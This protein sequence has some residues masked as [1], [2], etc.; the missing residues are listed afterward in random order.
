[1]ILRILLFLILLQSEGT[2]VRWGRQLWAVHNFTKLYICFRKT[3][4]LHEVLFSSEFLF[5]IKCKI[6]TAAQQK[7]YDKL[8]YLCWKSDSEVKVFWRLQGLKFTQGWDIHRSHNTIVSGHVVRQVLRR[9][10]IKTFWFAGSVPN[11][12]VCRYWWNDSTLKPF[13][14]YGNLYFKL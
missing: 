3:L 9:L 4:T 10:I 11:G 12:S 13:D 14:C 5:Q 7:K 8:H 2:G 1:M 6:Q